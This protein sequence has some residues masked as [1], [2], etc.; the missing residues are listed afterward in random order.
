MGVLEAFIS[1]AQYLSDTAVFGVG[2]FKYEE[3]ISKSIFGAVVGGPT[4]Y[5]VKQTVGMYPVGSFEREY[6]DF[7]LR[8]CREFGNKAA[9]EAWK[10]YSK[11]LNER[12]K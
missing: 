9:Y 3:L 2:E 6:M 1:G 10:Y 11:A 4:A 5:M 7:T 8:V 12:G